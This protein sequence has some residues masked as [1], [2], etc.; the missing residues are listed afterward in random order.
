MSRLI[1]Y[2]KLMRLHRPIGI[3]LVLWPTLWALWLAADGMPDLSVLVVF[4]LGVIIMRSAGC[5]IND[6]ADRD[7][8]G[9]VMRTKDRPLATGQLQP[10]QALR[11]FVLLILVAAGLVWTQNYTTILWSLGAVALTIVYPFMKRYTHWPQ[12]I[13][14]AAFAWAI[15]MA[16]AAQTGTVPAYA[17]LLYAATLSWTVAFDTIYAMIDRAD[18]E[19]IGIKSTARLFGRYDRYAIAGFQWMFLSLMFWVARWKSLGI[20]FWCSYIVVVGLFVYQQRLIKTRRPDS[21]FRAFMNN[22]WIGAVLFFGIAL[23]Y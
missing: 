5:V 16:F 13:L 4:I 2:A 20:V 3:Y 6:Y 18:D 7:F 1:L 23:N 14:G 12:V 19:K 22:H 17:W 21:Y 10:K 11:L 9:A 15:P 8:D